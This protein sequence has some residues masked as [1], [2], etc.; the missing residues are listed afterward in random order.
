[1]KTVRNVPGGGVRLGALLVCTLLSV[2]LAPAADAAVVYTYTGK[3]FTST[4]G[5]YSCVDGVG[6]CQ[7]KGYFVLPQIP[8]S[9]RS[10]P[11]RCMDLNPTSSRCRA[12]FPN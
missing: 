10:K 1:M 9:H 12:T 4:W 8:A 5:D 6:V 7:I 3:P 2:A 11:L